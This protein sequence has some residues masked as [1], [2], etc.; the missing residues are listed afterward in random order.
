MVSE[1]KSKNSYPMD[2]TLFTHDT[3]LLVDI[4][5]EA[6]KHATH[7]FWKRVRNHF[8]SDTI[9]SIHI[10]CFHTGVD[11][12]ST[13]EASASDGT[14]SSSSTTHTEVKPDTENDVSHRIHSAK[15]VQA[16]QNVLA[17]LAMKESSGPR[18]TFST[19]GIFPASDVSPTPMDVTFS[20][21]N[22]QSIHFEKLLRSWTRQN[23][24]ILCPKAII[25]FDLPET[26]DGTVCTLT[27]ELSY[28]ILPF[29]FN[30][31]ETECLAKEMKQISESTFSVL[32]LVPLDR[33]DL[34][35]I[36]GVPI[37]AKAG[38][39]GDIDQYKEMQKISNVLLRYLSLN[40]SALVL[41]CDTISQDVVSES[42]IYLLMAKESTDYSNFN[43]ST[44]SFMNA[45]IHR[46]CSKTTR[47]LEDDVVCN[48]ESAIV[49]RYDDETYSEV[50]KSALECLP[51]EMIRP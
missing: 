38:L 44:T 8:T 24:S 23:F 2:I 49:D 41:Q 16:I 40:D 34:S 10:L 15:C 1:S 33:I 12:L 18:N 3:A 48:V 14:S 45:T 20:V 50:V 13:E 9:R 11:V 35:L 7:R 21:Q 28:R 30:S 26:M 6:H 42:S 51:N 43:S 36:Y 25:S 17:N 37:V 4:K 39:Q 29:H 19:S 22:C 46:Y 32:Q 5:A 47:I 27:L 31:I